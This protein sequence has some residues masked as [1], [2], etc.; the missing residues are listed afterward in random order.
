MVSQLPGSLCTLCGFL[1][2]EMEN[3]LEA[4]EAREQRQRIS[5][6][7]C[8]TEKIMLLRVAQPRQGLWVIQVA[9]FS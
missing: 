1:A 9:S 4:Y 5:L 3:F 6:V 7:L 8:V 2:G